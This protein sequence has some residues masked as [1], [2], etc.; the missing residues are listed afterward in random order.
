M[1]VTNKRKHTFYG[2]LFFLPFGIF[3]LIFAL[4]PFIRSIILGF[5][6]WDVIG[7]PKFIGIENFIRIFKDPLFWSSLKNT[8]YF[9]LLTVPPLIILGFISA[10]FASSVIL[11]PKI[12]SFLRISFYLPYVLPISVIC[13]VWGML[14]SPFFG[15]F[16]AH[17]LK[18]LGFSPVFWREN[19]NL[20]MLVV[21]ITTIWWTLGFNFLMYFSA[22]QQIPISVIEASLLDGTTA[23][24]RVIYIIIPLLRR[25][26]VLL[27]V[28][29][30]VAS[31]QIFGQI[32][33]MTGG[34]PGGKTRVF[35]QYIYEMGFRYFKMGYAQA[36][37]FIFFLIMFS[38]SYL[39]VKLMLE[40]GE[41]K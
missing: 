21:A 28:L 3:F 38:I 16:N 9:T 29:Q 33:I 39:Q 19:P 31:L 10:I 23:F 11:R 2:Y 4:V 27:L 13:L 40:A 20:A 15:L 35:I 7:T 30:I 6:N 17:L 22:L 36:M 34:G 5:Y 14:T 25:T 41:E 37:A 18:L 8:L 26:H 32:Y 1:I 24:Q 12:R